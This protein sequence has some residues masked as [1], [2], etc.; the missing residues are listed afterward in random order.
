M[1]LDRFLRRRYKPIVAACC[2]L[3]SLLL[4]LA[5][6]G[7]VVS[8]GAL[9][10]LALAAHQRLG[11][12]RLS[13]PTS[14]A[15]IAVDERSLDSTELQNKPRQFLGA[16]FARMLDAAAVAGA[17]GIGFDFV[18]AFDS[19]R[20]PVD[21]DASFRDALKRHRNRV[22][23]GRSVQRLP[24]PPIAVAVPDDAIAYLELPQDVDGVSRHVPAAYRVLGGGLDP[25]APT[26]SARMLALAGRKMPA[27]IL[28]APAWHLETLPTYSLIDVLRCAE[29]EP[30]R[31]R[32]AFADRLVLVGTTFPDEDR[33]IPPSRLVTPPAGPVIATADCRMDR[34]PASNPDS[35]TV[36]GVHIHA[37]GI[38]AGFDGRYLAIAQPMAASV[39]SG[40]AGLAGAVLALNLAPMAMIAALIVGLFGFL[41]LS[42]TL[43]VW[44]IWLPISLVAAG[45]LASAGV[46]YGAA[47]FVEERRRRWIQRI[48][49]HYLAPAII[50][51]LT[52]AEKPPELGG[53]RRD[54]TV[55]FADLSGFTALSGRLPPQDL[56]DLTN[57]YLT[58]IAEEI[59]KSGGYVDKFIG[60]AVM[61]VW[62][63]PTH[64]P[65]HACHAVGAALAIARRIADERAAALARGEEGFWVKI[66]IN[67]GPA[68]VGNAGSPRRLAYTVVGETVNL[69]ARFESLPGDYGCMIVIGERTA[70]SLDGAYPV[71]ELDLIKVKGAVAPVR[72]YE[73]FPPGGDLEPYL[74]GYGR[75]LAAYRDR[76]FRDA[77]REWLEIIYLGLGDPKKVDADQTGYATPNRVMAARAVAFAAAPPLENWHGEWLRES[78]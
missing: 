61:A 72:I 66:G 2:G 27:D 46:S 49:G 28:I 48:F 67:S 63:A 45:F 14:V 26:M 68:I 6:E 47:F 75:A 7:A 51:K 52:A 41:I 10:D 40:V 17:T 69:A 77:E 65:A 56:M 11:I 9:F 8:D 62:G 21:V 60:D 54:I 5:N 70:N 30:E 16:E 34:R 23:L 12:N 19:Q 33:R 55:M 1:L 59:D 64:D 35:S 36:P 38:E 22:V 43:L 71:C 31:L 78:K 15:V 29:Q 57:R 25:T 3:V 42:G 76:C 20:L 50:E 4:A 39:A 24:V 44:G 32:Q 18:F 73:P 37:A 13:E 53:E 58:L 74:K